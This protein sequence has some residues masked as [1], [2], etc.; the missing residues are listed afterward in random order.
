MEAAQSV[1]HALEQ[2]GKQLVQE[3]FELKGPPQSIVEARDRELS[4]STMEQLAVVKIW[5]V[6]LK[7]DDISTELR[8]LGDKYLMSARINRCEA[9]QR[10]ADEI[11]QNAKEQVQ[12]C[13]FDSKPPP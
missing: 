12:K 1:A 8:D 9:A 3:F 13:F 10:V 5:M 11:V 6:M 4:C 2:Y 7:R